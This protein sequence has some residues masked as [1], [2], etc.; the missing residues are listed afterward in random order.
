MAKIDFTMNDLK[1][2]SIRYEEGQDVT[3]EVLRNA[4]KAYRYFHDQ[5]LSLKPDLSEMRDIHYSFIFHD[6]SLEYFVACAKDMVAHGRK[7]SLE[8]FGCYLEYID[9][10]NEL[11][12]LIRND[13]NSIYYSRT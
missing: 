13:Y 5:F 8:I 11:S 12:A 6:V 10:Y 7:D 3:L 4:Q 1:A 9:S 2:S